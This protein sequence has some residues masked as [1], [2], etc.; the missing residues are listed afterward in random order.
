MSHIFSICKLMRISLRTPSDSEYTI[1]IAHTTRRYEN[2]NNLKPSRNTRCISGQLLF[3]SLIN[4]RFELIYGIIWLHILYIPSG[5]ATNN[6]R[7]RRRSFVMCVWW[8]VGELLLAWWLH[9]TKNIYYP[10]YIYNAQKTHISHI[11]A[12]HHEMNAS[13]VAF[14]LCGGVAIERRRRS[15]AALSP[16]KNL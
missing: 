9:Q 8:S 16:H 6:H 7:R 12:Y 3:T 2:C 14:W 11:Y 10:I 5:D 4:F 15:L 13:G 1:F